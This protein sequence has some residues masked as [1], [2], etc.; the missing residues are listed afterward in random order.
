MLFKQFKKNTK[1][2]FYQII[3]EQED[4]FILHKSIKSRNIILTCLI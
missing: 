1:T 2:N 3:M 4:I